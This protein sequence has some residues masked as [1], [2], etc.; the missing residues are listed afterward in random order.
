MS[1]IPAKLAYKIK[2]CI[3]AKFGVINKVGKVVNE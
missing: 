3:V 2:T 1:Q